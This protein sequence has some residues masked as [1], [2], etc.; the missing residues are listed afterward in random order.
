M[1]RGLHDGLFRKWYINGQL[2]FSGHMESNKEVGEWNR[3][4]PDGSIERTYI[5]SKH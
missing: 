3:Y 2:C 1:S 5:F 4:F